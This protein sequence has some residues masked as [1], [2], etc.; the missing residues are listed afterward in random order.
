M[1][2]PL[3]REPEAQADAANTTGRAVAKPSRAAF[4]GAVLPSTAG[5]GSVRR[6]RL[7]PARRRSIFAR[8]PNT[9]RFRGAKRSSRIWLGGQCSL[10]DGE[11]EVVRFRHRTTGR[12]VDRQ[13]FR[14]L[15]REY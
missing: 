11:T 14:G 5:C 12:R 6:N 2:Y 4:A 13:T 8:C 1:R 3:L 15:G 7:E 10:A 9:D